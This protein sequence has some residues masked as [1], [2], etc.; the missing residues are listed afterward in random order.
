[1]KRIVTFALFIVCT[2]TAAI[3]QSEAFTKEFY[4]YLNTGWGNTA[5]QELGTEAYTGIFVALLSEMPDCPYKTTAEINSAAAQLAK[6]YNDEQAKQDIVAIIAPSFEKHLTVKELQNINKTIKSDKKLFEIGKKLGNKEI[7]TNM[8]TVISQSMMSTMMKIAQGQEPEPILAASEKQDKLYIAVEEFCQSCGVKDMMTGTFA[9]GLASMTG[10]EQQKAI[11]MALLEY[12][13]QEIPSAYY[14]SVN[15]KV[16]TDEIV[17]ITKFYQT[18]LGQKLVAGT[19]ES[20][21]NPMALG[22]GI[23]TKITDWLNT[24][25]LN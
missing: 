13:A 8:S 18:P 25:Q 5:S 4:N 15:G 12:I 14:K 2:L 23:V 6:K 17:Y 1:M 19:V 10:D 16:T 21:S 7:I 20:M 3:A 11:M 22:E 24:Q 9:Q